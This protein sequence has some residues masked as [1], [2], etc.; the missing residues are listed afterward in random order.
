VADPAGHE[1]PERQEGRL[2][3]RGPSSTSGYYRDAEKT[4]NLFEGDWLDSGDLAYMAN[5][6]VYITGRIKDIIIRA[7]RNI[8]PHE[9]EEAVGL[10]AGIRTGRVAVFGSEDARSGT[11]R[12]IVLAETRSKNAAERDK[13][14]AEINVLATDLLGAPPDDIVLAPPGTV[15]KT[16]SGKIRRAA[17]REIFEKGRI[18]KSHRSVSWQV[19]RLALASIRPQIR[20]SARYAKAA[21]YAVYCW[22]VYALLAP[23][24]WL[25]VTLLPNFSLRWTVMKRCS[26]LLAKATATPVKLNGLENLPADGRPYVLASNHSSYLDAYVLVA[27]LPGH[28]RF[29]AKAE[30]AESFIIRVPLQH[31]HTEFVERFDTSKSVRDTRHLSDVLKAGHALVFFAE[32]TFTRTPG[33]MPFHLGA[34]SVAAQAGAPVIPV[35]IRGTRSILRSRSWFPQRG[36]ISVDI[37]PPIDPMEFMREADEDTWRVAIGMR[38]RS[39]EFILRHCGEPDLAR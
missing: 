24:V 22:V 29:I 5:G 2:Q 11:E 3:F 8:Y 28:F 33:L 4:Q 7:G 39:R 23:A 19:A 27:T 13:L 37:G 36:A 35:A 32:G 20:R 17:S 38:D 14:R 18:G 21:S 25:S 26:Q 9:L 10:I 15:L 12:L 34:F 31:I 30:L 16:S 1:L 6:E